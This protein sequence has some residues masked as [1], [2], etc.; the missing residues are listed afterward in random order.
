[1][2]A[3]NGRLEINLQMEFMIVEGWDSREN[4][5]CPIAKTQEGKTVLFYREH[6]NIMRPG[7]TWLCRIDT[8][9][10]THL[11]AVPLERKSGSSESET[12]RVAD[13]KLPDTVS[14]VIIAN[15]SI[16]L[17]ETEKELKKQEVLRAAA[18]KSVAALDE[19]MKAERRVL[20]EAQ[21]KEA[22]AR[23]M[24]NDLRSSL[25]KLKR[26][27]AADVMETPAAFWERKTKERSK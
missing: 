11:H 5:A 21:A 14:Q 4:R 3:G 16:S 26:L 8:I 27:A 19:Q 13:V 15:L 20:A 22:T 23:N 24:A 10:D 17:S 6:H 25:E 7:E 1:M 9:R 18:E 2:E 12:L